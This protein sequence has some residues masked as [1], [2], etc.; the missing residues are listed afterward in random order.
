ML[1]CCINVICL[2]KIQTNKTFN[3]NCCFVFCY[4]SLYLNNENVI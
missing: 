3:K 4:Y 2:K 1:F